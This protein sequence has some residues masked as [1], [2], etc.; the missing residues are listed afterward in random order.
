M[1][2]VVHYEDGD[3][4]VWFFSKLLGLIAWLREF[5][6]RRNPSSRSASSPKVEKKVSFLSHH[7]RHPAEAFLDQV[8][9]RSLYPSPNIFIK[10][11][12]RKKLA[13]GMPVTSL[14]AASNITHSAIA[15]QDSSRVTMTF[16]AHCTGHCT[17]EDFNVNFANHNA[18]SIPYRIVHM[19]SRAGAQR[20]GSWN[21]NWVRSALHYKV[22]WMYHELWLQEVVL[23]E[24]TMELQKPEW[25]F[26]IRSILSV[27]A[28][29]A[30]LVCGVSFDYKRMRL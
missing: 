19:I 9:I 29:G 10:W 14:N 12:N 20:T 22:V 13:L 28:L 16:N 27:P 17:V 1:S 11:W 2:S 4:K 5:M 6:S 18:K 8:A 30:F 23:L 15:S 21:C 7:V 3:I 26:F 25:H 24:K